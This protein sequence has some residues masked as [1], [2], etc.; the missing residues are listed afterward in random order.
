MRSILDV[1]VTGSFRDILD[2]NMILIDSIDIDSMSKKLCNLLLTK[3]GTLYL[4]RRK[5]MDG[6]CPYFKA[7]SVWPSGFFDTKKSVNI[8]IH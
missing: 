1:L 4:G 7:H 3:V 6:S 8:P 5:V 2:N